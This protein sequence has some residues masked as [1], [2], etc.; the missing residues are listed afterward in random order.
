[1]RHFVPPGFGLLLAEWENGEYPSVEEIKVGWKRQRQ[2]V[3]SLPDEVWRPRAEQWVQ[4]LYVLNNL[5][6]SH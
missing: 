2:L 5:S 4:G 6:S 3:I 1:M